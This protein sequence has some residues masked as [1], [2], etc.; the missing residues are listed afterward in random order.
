MRIALLALSYDVLF[1][2]VGGLSDAVFKASGRYAL[3]AMLG[4][5]SR[6]VQ[7]GG[8]ILGLIWFRSFSGVAI[9][10]CIARALMTILVIWFGQRESGGLRLGFGN[11]GVKDLKAMLY[12]AL[13]FMAFAITNALSF[14]GITLLVGLL[15]G[16]PAVALFNSYRTLARIAVQF[17][18]IF[19]LALWPEFARLYGNGGL[20]RVY[21]AFRRSMSLGFVI[22]TAVS[23]ALY[24]VSSPLLR[25]WSHGRIGFSPLLMFILLSYA[26]VGGFWHVPRVLLMSINQHMSLS[27]W[28]IFTA[29][30][31]VALGWRLGVL[32]GVDGVALSMLLS[33]VLISSIC[34]YLALRLF[35]HRT[36]LVKV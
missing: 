9:I 27:A 14:Q 7:W 16:P 24:C 4:Q 23:S 21:P 13:S 5:M 10:G 6:L 29:L 26:A 36:Q 17:T 18:S 25:L 33:E 3:G 22:S 12:P 15:A 2:L 30:T 19:S 35:E 20:E 34:V 1:S 31:S 8:F 28:S 32:W 11:A